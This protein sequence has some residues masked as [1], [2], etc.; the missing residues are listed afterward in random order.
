LFEQC[1]LVLGDG[2][3]LRLMARL[4]ATYEEIRARHTK[5]E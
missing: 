1:L 3:V 2:L 4:G 5:L